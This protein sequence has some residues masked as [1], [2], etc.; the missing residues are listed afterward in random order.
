MDALIGVCTIQA[1]GV[2]PC[3]CRRVSSAGAGEGVLFCDCSSLLHS[4]GGGQV[5]DRNAT[6]RGA[7][8]VAG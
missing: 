5:V 6:D 4:S 2:V 8:T 3:V 1:H 7:K